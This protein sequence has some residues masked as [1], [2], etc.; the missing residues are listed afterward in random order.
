MIP[1]KIIITEVPHRTVRYRYLQ[2]LS[3]FVYFFGRS[4][5]LCQSEQIEADILG[6]IWCGLAR[7][8]FNLQFK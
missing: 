6:S 5:K 3:N 2:F 4:Q 1:S 8:Q 7:D